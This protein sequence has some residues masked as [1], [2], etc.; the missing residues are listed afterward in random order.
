MF[1][2]E[3]PIAPH[4]NSFVATISEKPSVGSWQEQDWKALDWL[5]ASGVRKEFTESHNGAGR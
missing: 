5:A 3:N 1:G 2:D 4:L